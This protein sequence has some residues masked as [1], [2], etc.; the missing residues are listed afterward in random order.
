MNES[1]TPR[2]HI[3]IKLEKFDGEYEEGKKPVEVI[4]RDYDF[5]DIETAEKFLKEYSNGNDQCL[6]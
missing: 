2:L 4:E 6:P 3:H 1:C 5:D